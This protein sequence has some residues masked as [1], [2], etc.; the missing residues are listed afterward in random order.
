MLLRKGST[1]RAVGE[2]GEALLALGLIEAAPEVFDTRL[3]RAV[4]AFQTQNLDPRGEPLVVDGVVGPLTRFAIDVALGARDPQSVAAEGEPGSPIGEAAL[5]VAREEAA[6]GAGEAGGNNR[7]PDI[8]VYLDGRAPE[9]S[10]WCAGF[11]SWCHRE[12]ARRLGRDMPFRYSLGARDIRN[13]FRAK[14]WAYAASAAQNP[15]PGDIVV[16]WRGAQS[17]WQGHIGLVE[18]CVDGILHTIEGNRGPYPSRVS[19]YRY[20]LGR[21]ERLLGFGRID[22]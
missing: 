2:L 17:G 18:R 3:D 5:A 9:G 8:R 21:M 15:R 4:R 1:G 11:V 19:R 16:W 14:G 6:R 20:V 12:A 10:E 7:G 13:Q 22:A